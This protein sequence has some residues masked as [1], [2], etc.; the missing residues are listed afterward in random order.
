[1]TALPLAQL[2]ELNTPVRFLMGPGPSDCHPRVLRAMAQP[3]VGHL[4]PSFVAILQDVK[5]LLQV[6]LKTKNDMTLAI[7]GTGSAGMETLCA[8]LLEPGDHAIIGVNGV[9]GGRMV[10]VAQRCGATV[11]KVEAPWGKPIDPQAVADALK[12]CPNPKM[13]A[14][15]HAETSTGA[16]T[17]LEE[18]GKLAH[19]A[20]ALFVVDAVTSVAGIDLRVD[21]WGIDALYSGTQ[22]CLSCPPGLSP[23]TFSPRAMEVIKGRKT[24]CQSWYLDIGMIASYWGEDRMYHHTAPIT[25]V[26]ALREA[27]RLVIEEGL[28]ARFA[29]HAAM[30]LKLRGALEEMGIEFIVDEAYRLPQLNAI[31]VPE[32]IDELAWRKKLL[33]DYNIEIGAGLGAFKGKVWRIGLMGA[34][35]TPNHVNM[36]VAALKDLRAKG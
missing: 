30:H 12:V 32:G 17:P 16:R 1:M 10:D 13:V 3:L 24:K 31:K 5:A 14:V 22:K 29:R 11:H 35:C 18:I 19:A 34:S 27:L 20:G 23:V 2:G 26:Y 36:L 25:M 15:V 7:S 21:E 33:T 9:F 28:E 8:N 4:D 6:V